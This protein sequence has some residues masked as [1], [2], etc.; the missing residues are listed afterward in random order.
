MRI[1]LLLIIL[2]GFVS[3]SSQTET[4]LKWSDFE[5][6]V[7]GVRASLP[8]TPKAS[9]K[10]FQDQPRPIHV[11]EFNCEIEG[12]GFLLSVKNHQNDFNSKMIDESFESTNSL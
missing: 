6:K 3:C 1:G 8:C 10:S 2:L 11:Y 5:S 12:I 4:G 7:A 9:D